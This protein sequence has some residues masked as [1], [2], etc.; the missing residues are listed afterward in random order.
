MNDGFIFRRFIGQGNHYF[1]KMLLALLVEQLIRMLSQQ[2]FA[3]FVA[4]QFQFGVKGNI[5]YRGSIK[6]SQIPNHVEQIT[7]YISFR[8]A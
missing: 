2:L 1:R 6:Q 4:D 8:G 5:I 7:E 3:T